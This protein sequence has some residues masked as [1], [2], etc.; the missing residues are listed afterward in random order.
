MAFERGAHGEPTAFKPALGRVG[1]GASGSGAI[2][3]ATDCIVIRV[4]R[5][6]QLPSGAVQNKL[7]PSELFSFPCGCFCT[8]GNG[9][10]DASYG[11]CHKNPSYK[12]QPRALQALRH[13][14]IPAR[15]MKR[16]RWVQPRQNL[17]AFFFFSLDKNTE[18]S[19]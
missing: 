14:S 9:R 3:A 6:C 8:R 15:Y 17:A 11:G 7:R 18:F 2:G 5:L 4:T 1:S 10:R 12:R 19:Y 16:L 13:T